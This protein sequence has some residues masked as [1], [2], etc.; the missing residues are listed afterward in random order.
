MN[1]VL[2]LKE[3]CRLIAGNKLSPKDYLA[4]CIKLGDQLEPKLHAFIRR[5]SFSEAVNQ[6]HSGPLQGIP[7]GIKDII[8]TQGMITTNGSPIYANHI[9]GEDASIVARIRE[10]GGVVL[11][12]TVTTEFAWRNPGPA[13]N[14]HNERHTPGGSSSG[15]AAAVASGIVPLAL[16]SQTQGSILRPAAFCGVVGFK[17]SFGA[18]PREGAFPLSGSCDHI[19]FFTRSVD[20]AAYAFN[21]L[22]NHHASEPGSIVVPDLPIS[23][24]SDLKMVSK[25]RLALL[26][27]P[28]DKLMSK[29]Q[30]AI[31]ALAERKFI[32]KGFLID[33]IELPKIYWQG[34]D[35][36]NC[37]IESEAAVIHQDH[38]KNNAKQL[39]IH[40]K[41]LAKK[42]SK[43][44]ATQYIN[45]RIDQI[46][47]REKIGEFFKQYDGFLS[48]PATGEAPLGLT[49]TGDPIFCALWSF[50]GL[51]AI[52]LPVTKSQNNLPMGIQLIG[53]Y[54]EDA[55]LLSL[56]KTAEKALKLGV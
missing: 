15:S 53:A 29:N 16:G 50:L 25:P 33:H 22:K 37:L 36:M 55:H 9:P 46:V 42:G 2:G 3:A 56:A 24:D 7:V 8:A 27:T 52:S 44:S 12:K 39:S 17:A 45:A 48:V 5:L 10:L 38:I 26:K 19:G 32:E 11:G 47:L 6:S 18:V 23:M 4:S 40:I 41:E 20:D 30:V 31:L 51:P 21:L 35:Q 14:P 54:G 43:Y 49:W 13:T 28:F 34:I 1:S